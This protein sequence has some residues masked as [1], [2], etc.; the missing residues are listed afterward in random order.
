MDNTHLSSI[1]TLEQAVAKGKGNGTIYFN[2]GMAYKG[3]GNV[4]KAV[5][6]FGL[7]V[8]YCPNEPYYWLYYGVCLYKV[9]QFNNAKMAMQQANAVG[10][11]WEDLYKAI[12]ASYN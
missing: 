3:L 11:Q 1:K 7:A 2:L 5:R 9:R 12:L 8:G 6:Y 4:Q 10:M